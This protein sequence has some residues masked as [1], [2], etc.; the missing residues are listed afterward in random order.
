MT[1]INKHFEKFVDFL[2]GEAE[3]GRNFPPFKDLCEQLGA[4]EA[5]LNEF[6]EEMFGVSGEKIVESYRTSTPISF[7]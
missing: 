2:E 4:P 1:D 7:L 5:E 6:L 3:G